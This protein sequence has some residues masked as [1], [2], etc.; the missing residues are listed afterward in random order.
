MA[1]TNHDAVKAFIHDAAVVH[2][3]VVDRR[4]ARSAGSLQEQVSYPNAITERLRNEANPRH[5]A[6]ASQL[7]DQQLA[8]QDIA[9]GQLGDAVRAIAQ[10]AYE[11]QTLERE[12]HRTQRHMQQQIHTHIQELTHEYDSGA[13]NA[14]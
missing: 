1:K 6:V 12:L 9:K 7:G 5:N 4:M 13:R 14:K 10:K 3:L 8:E 2:Q 11:A